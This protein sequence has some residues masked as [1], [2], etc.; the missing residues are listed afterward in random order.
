MESEN[1]SLEDLKDSICP[2][3]KDIFKVGVIHNGEYIC[4]KCF[5][6]GQKEVKR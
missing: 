2:I 4:C 1:W 6:K 3:C 5:D